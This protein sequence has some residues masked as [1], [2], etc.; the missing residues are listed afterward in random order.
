MRGKFRFVV[1]ALVMSV[2]LVGL[3]DAKKP[4]PTPCAPGRYLLPAS[5]G[6]LTGDTAPEIPLVLQPGQSMLGSCPLK[7]GSSR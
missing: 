1:S 3:A 7:A 2:A 5:I 6:N 4:K